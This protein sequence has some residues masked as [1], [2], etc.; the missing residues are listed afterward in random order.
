M[1]YSFSVLFKELLFAYLLILVASLLSGLR[2][3]VPSWGA[4]G[5][6]HLGAH[7]L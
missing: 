1:S 4:C 6:V 5:R 7:V 3:L 2:S